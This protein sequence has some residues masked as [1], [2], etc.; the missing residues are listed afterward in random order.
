MQAVEEG[1][2][3]IPM[4]NQLNDI[5]EVS[6]PTRGQLELNQ[7]DQI[8]VLNSPDFLANV[9]RIWESNRAWP[10]AAGE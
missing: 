4:A 9:R 5:P 1:F 10:T 3:K 8:D 6:V 7:R 2:I